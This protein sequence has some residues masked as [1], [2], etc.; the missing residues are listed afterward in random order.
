MTF[1]VILQL[2]KN[3]EIFLKFLKDYAL[4]KN[5][6]SEKDNSGYLR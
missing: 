4:N 6:I 5:C 2:M 3:V 1:E